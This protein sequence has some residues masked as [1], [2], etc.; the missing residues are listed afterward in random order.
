MLKKIIFLVVLCCIA[1]LTTACQA[2]DDKMKD[3]YYTAQAEGYSHGWKEFIT[4]SVKNNKV[5]SA[6]YNAENVSGFIKS[7]DNAY[8]KNMKNLQGTY[9]NSYTRN[10]SAQLLNAQTSDGVELIVG[11]TTSGDSFKK[12]SEAVIDQAKKGDSSVVTVKTE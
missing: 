6:E 4:I 1:G 12:L 3:G 10:Y 11:A 2:S 5:I 9:P 7:W 8:M